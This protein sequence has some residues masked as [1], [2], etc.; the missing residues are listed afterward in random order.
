VIGKLKI[1]KKP[2]YFCTRLNLRE[3]TGLRARNLKELV[4]TI[5]IVPGSSIFHHTHMFLQ[6]NLRMS[7]EH[8]ND[9]AYWVT[10]ALGEYKLGEQLSSID[11][12]EFGSIREIRERI[13][14]IIEKNLF[15]RQE[16]LRQAPLGRE[17]EFVKSHSFI[18]PTPYTA[19]NLWQFIRILKKVTIQSI[20]FHMFEAKLRLERGTNDF[21]NWIE[22]SLNKPALA[23]KIASIDP[24][25]YTLESL[26]EKIIDIVESNL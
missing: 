2:F 26:R 6:Q 23:K 25:T 5:K 8:P 11:L 13:I 3:L 12:L 1:A 19:Y 4:E 22:N 9:F 24:Y 17:F 16:S 20:Y 15:E 10:G 18:L 7:P 21:S 14:S